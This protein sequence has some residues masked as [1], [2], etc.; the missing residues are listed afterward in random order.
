MPSS[1]SSGDPSAARHVRRPSR[2]RTFQHGTLD[3]VIEMKRPL[4]TWGNAVLLAIMVGYGLYA[5]GNLPQLDAFLD[6]LNNK[7]R[8]HNDVVVGSIIRYGFGIVVTVAFLLLSWFVFLYFNSRARQHADEQAWDKEAPAPRPMRKAEPDKAIVPDED[9][10]SLVMPLHK[11]IKAEPVV[12]AAPAAPVAIA[13]VAAPAVQPAAPVAEATVPAELEAAKLEA[14]KPENIAP[15]FA[16]PVPKPDAAGSTPP[17]NALKAAA[18]A[19]A[20]KAEAIAADA[21]ADLPSFV[22]PLGK[23]AK[24]KKIATPTPVTDAIPPHPAVVALTPPP[25]AVTPP[26]PTKI[27]AA[28][29]APPKP[30]ATNLDT[31]VAAAKNDAAIATAK[32]EAAIAEAKAATARAEAAMA[33]AKAEAAVAE[34]ALAAARAQAALTAATAA[35][36]PAP[37]ASST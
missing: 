15:G 10:P 30:D 29:P 13:A 19:A 8:A 12:V 22:P 1:G 26:V 37:T 5:T 6:N 2:T 14:A 31:A 9:A 18:I 28:P 4:L 16:K 25:A 27:D 21:P 32:A 35:D 36:K 20:A 23:V 7:G 3:P 34:A 24:H 33:T 11:A 17:I